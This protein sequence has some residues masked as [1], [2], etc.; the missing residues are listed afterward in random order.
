MLLY[1][2]KADVET[3]LAARPGDLPRTLAELIAFNEQHR[4]EE[5]GPFGQEIF[6]KAEAK[7]PLTE[8]AYLEALATCGRLAREEGLD[9][10]LAQHRLDA[11]VAPTG[12]PAWLIDHVNGDHYAGGNSS[13][14][15]IAGYPSITVP[16]GSVAGLPVGMSFIG[17]PWTEAKLIR[18]AFAFERATSHR[19]PPTFPASIAQ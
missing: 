7:G 5:L 8:P 9:A 11:I 10:V 1:E 19:H 13:P 17:A 4:H 12:G 6:E 2:F 16:M 18:S 15:A 14:A 3:Y